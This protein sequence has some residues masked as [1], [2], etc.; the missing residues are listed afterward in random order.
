MYTVT[1][2]TNHYSQW[3]L[4]PGNIL[5]IMM[6]ISLYHPS[7]HPPTPGG[8]SWGPRRS[9]SPSIHPSIHGPGHDAIDEILST[10]LVTFS[11]KHLQVHNTLLWPHDRRLIQRLSSAVAGQCQPWFLSI[12]C[13]WVPGPAR[14]CQWRRHSHRSNTVWFGVTDR[15]KNTQQTGWSRVHL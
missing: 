13:L 9:H 14:Q 5:L 8:H 2:T 11:H 4:P 15:L 10:I 12:S 6:A 3:Y 1:V 7:A